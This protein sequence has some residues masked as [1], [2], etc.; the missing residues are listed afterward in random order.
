MTRFHE[1]HD[2]VK[3]ILNVVQKSFN[4][5]YVQLFNDVAK[6]AVDIIYKVSYAS[7]V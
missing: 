5:C 7:Y 4:E 3:R 6:H 1:N 2:L